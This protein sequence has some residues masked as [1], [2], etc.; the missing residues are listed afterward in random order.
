[1]SKDKKKHKNKK[2]RMPLNSKGPQELPREIGK[3]KLHLIREAINVQPD[4]IFSMYLLWSLI[5]DVKY[6][7]ILVNGR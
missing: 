5:T 3:Q 2:N 4:D 6:P 1:M 7:C